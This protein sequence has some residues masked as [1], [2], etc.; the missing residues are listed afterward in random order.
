LVWGVQQCVVCTTRWIDT[1]KSA[2][3]PPARVGIGVR[4]K[5]PD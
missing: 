1:S 4:V 5:L 3:E 2:D